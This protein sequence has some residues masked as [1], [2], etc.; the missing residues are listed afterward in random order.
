MTNPGYSDLLEEA[1][2]GWA[3]VRVEGGATHAPA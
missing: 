3:G 2:E 1:L